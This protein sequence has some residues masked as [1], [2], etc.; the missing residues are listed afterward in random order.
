MWPFKRKANTYTEQVLNTAVQEASGSAIGR[1]DLVAAVVA[2]SNFWA[3]KFSQVSYEGP[4][5][6]T[7]SHRMRIAR[8][9]VELGHT[10]FYLNGQ[11][12]YIPIISATKIKRGWSITIPDDEQTKS[13]TVLDAEVLNIVF[14]PNRVRPYEGMPLGRSGTGRLARGLDSFMGDE[15][16]GPAGKFLWINHAPY[17]D[18]DARRKIRRGFASMFSFAAASKFRGKFSPIL[19]PA[20][21]GKEQQT[22]ITRIGPDWPES[23]EKTRAQ[24]YKEIASQCGVPVELLIGGSAASIREG[25]RIFALTAQG[26]CDLISFHLTEFTGQKVIL[27]ASPLFKLDLISRSRAVGSLTNAGVSVSDALAYAGFEK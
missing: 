5:E 2:S 26:I 7:L 9:Y 8:D 16:N 3:N 23:L 4:P 15:A 25:N 21:S 22:T 13:L 12:Q 6:I 11:G 20:P 17:G 1:N 24:L 19:N 14:R 27:D 18:E 10:R